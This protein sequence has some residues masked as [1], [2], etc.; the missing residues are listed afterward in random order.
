MTE[1]T[2]I[3]TPEAED[4][5]LSVD[6]LLDVIGKQHQEIESLK[7]Q[8][9][10]MEN[11]IRLTEK[12]AVQNENEIDWMNA[13]QWGLASFSCMGVLLSLYFELYAK[14]RFEAKIHENNRFAVIEFIESEAQKGGHD[15]QPHVILNRLLDKLHEHQEDVQSNG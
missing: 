3:Q 8:V 15:A 14:P 12:Q 11:E 7:S 10:Q 1:N 9:I 13:L 6:D 2:N 5:Q 4:I